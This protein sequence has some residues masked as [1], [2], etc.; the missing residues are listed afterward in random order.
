MAYLDSGVPF[1][2]EAWLEAARASTGSVRLRP[3]RAA[4]LQFT[5]SSAS[6]VVRYGLTIDEGV[7]WSGGDLTKPDIEVRLDMEHAWRVFCGGCDGSEALARMSVIESGREQ[8]PSPID[9]GDQLELGEL[10]D[11]PGATLD[12]QYE[13]S[14]GPWGDVGF[15][16]GFVDGRVAKIGLGP[17]AEPD[18]VARC[19][20]LQMAQVRRGE[21]G[22]LDVLAAGGSVDGPEGALALLGG[23]SECAEFRRAEEAC[24]G[25]GM[26]LGTLGALQSSPVYQLALEE[27][28]SFTT[29]PSGLPEE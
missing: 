16:L 6:E 17:I 13:Y 26:A 24:G 28:R 3:G 10:P 1:L 8:R 22:I 19:T 11:V 21:M 23:I 7:Q 12:V 18:V 14:E 2:S 4:T 9:L 20:F 25:S 5:V 15:H 27:M 29:R